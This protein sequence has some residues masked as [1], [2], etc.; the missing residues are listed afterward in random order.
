MAG[1]P[2]EIT[3]KGGS[4]S[5]TLTSKRASGNTVYMSERQ[6]EAMRFP[7]GCG[8]G[9]GQFP[10]GP[11]GL[12]VALLLLHSCP[13]PFPHST[14][15]SGWPLSQ[16]SRHSGGSG[17]TR[18]GPT[19]RCTPEI[20]PWLPSLRSELVSTSP[21]RRRPPP[22][23]MGA[24]WSGSFGKPSLTEGG[25]RAPWHMSMYSVSFEHGCYKNK[26]S[27]STKLRKYG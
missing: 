15:T 20:Q 11:S 3:Q 18:P 6:N 23:A 26:Q 25:R 2:P 24:V 13:S 19:S 10:A 7:V 4:V 16:T 5:R 21:E 17:E 1:S 22:C 27:Q 8:L 9:L 12:D 14:Q